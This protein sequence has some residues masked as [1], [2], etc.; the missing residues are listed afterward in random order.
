M[1]YVV[2]IDDTICIPGPT[3]ETKYT[4][5]T[6]IPERISKI[7][8]LYIQGNRIIYHTARGMGNTR[9]LPNLRTKHTISLSSN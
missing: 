6:P 4:G 2:D 3:E 1:N 8:N 7:N 9:T 5:A